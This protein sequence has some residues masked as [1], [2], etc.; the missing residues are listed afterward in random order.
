[1]SF[2]ASAQIASQDLEK[3]ELEELIVSDN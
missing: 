3:F 1:V 2:D